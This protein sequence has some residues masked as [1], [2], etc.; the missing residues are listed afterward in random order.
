[1]GRNLQTISVRRGGSGVLAA[2]ISA[3]FWGIASLGSRKEEKQALQGLAHV[4][5]GFVRARVG[6]F[7][8]NV[9][10]LEIR[11]EDGS[12]DN[13]EKDIGG[14]REAGQGIARDRKRGEWG[15]LKLWPFF[16]SSSSSSF[17]HSNSFKHPLL[18][19]LINPKTPSVLADRDKLLWHMVWIVNIVSRFPTNRSELVRNLVALAAVPIYC[20]FE[21]AAV[22]S[23]NKCILLKYTAPEKGVE[24]P[25]KLLR[26]LHA[27]NDMFREQEQHKIHVDINEWRCGFCKKSFRAEK[28]LD[29][30][31][32]N[33][34]YNLLNDEVWHL[35]SDLK[36]VILSLLLDTSNFTRGISPSSFNGA[37]FNGLFYSIIMDPHLEYLLVPTSEMLLHIQM[38]SQ[39]HCLADL[40]GA[41]HCDSVMESKLP[42]S[43]CN[44]AAAARNLRRKLMRIMLLMMNHLILSTEFFLRQFCDAHTCSGKQKPFSRGGKRGRHSLLK[45]V[46]S[47]VEE[48]IEGSVSEMCSNQC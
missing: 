15:G 28:F 4:C 8:F 33:R 41:L 24:Q 27:D 21:K 29:Q 14:R 13:T 6:W 38:K 35:P 48:S 23:K 31:F 44:P 20:V 26:R 3:V 2:G 11:Q 46:M 17:L 25:G 16:L 43:K 32:D 5:R 10:I 40:C 1:M 30:H 39:G 47:C 36:L 12:G 18:R 34:H 22:M 7:N 19:S 45:W 9:W 42:K 37:V